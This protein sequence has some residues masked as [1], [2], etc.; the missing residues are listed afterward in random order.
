M[1]WNEPKLPWDGFMT[2][3]EIAESH[4]KDAARTADSEKLAEFAREAAKVLRQVDAGTEVFFPKSRPE[5]RIR[6][7]AIKAVQA[8]LEKWGMGE[9]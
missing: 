2:I 3:L 1:G 4:L 9:K 7:S 6:Q 8:L 5:Y